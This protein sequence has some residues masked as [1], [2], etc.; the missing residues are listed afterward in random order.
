M[1][2]LLSQT[3]KRKHWEN[4]CRDWNKRRVWLRMQ[5]KE[6]RISVVTGLVLKYQD[7][8]VWVIILLG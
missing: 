5:I 4:S 2:D 1:R 7:H 8:S 6:R 3:T